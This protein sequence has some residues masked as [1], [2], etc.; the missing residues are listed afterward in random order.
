MGSLSFD[1]A[2]DRDDNPLQRRNL[3]CYDYSMDVY[4]PQKLFSALKELQVIPSD[5]LQQ[6]FE[7]SS[8]IKVPFDQV[9]VQRDLISDENVGKLISELISVPYIS[10]TK[11][12]IP[13][14]VIKLLPEEYAKQ[15]Q[16][17]VF[18]TDPQTIKLAT[19][20]PKDQK[21]FTFIQKK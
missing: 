13:D 11:M 14:E 5:K 2:Q 12:V 9:L 19:S 16:V 1:F 10:L 7:E 3:P 20:N 8:R 6:A 15:H 17:I 4:D 21:L 18:A